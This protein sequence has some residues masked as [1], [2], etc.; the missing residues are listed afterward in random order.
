MASGPLTDGTGTAQFLLQNPPNVCCFTMGGGGRPF[1]RTVML[2]KEDFY[3]P[4]LLTNSSGTCIF[5]WQDIVPAGMRTLPA[6]GDMTQFAQG[7]AV[8][9]DFRTYYV[10]T[11]T[12]DLIMH[13]D[14]TFS[15]ATLNGFGA[16]P[17]VTGERLRVID[18]VY[19]FQVSLGYDLDDS[20]DVLDAN[21]A[22][23][24]LHN[25]PGES[26]GALGPGFDKAKLKLVRA[27]LVVGFPTGASAPSLARSPARDPGQLA[28]PGV[29]LR[30]VGTVLAPR[31]TP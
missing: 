17:T 30:A 16:D 18:G 28:V 21:G 13:M 23:E 1:V 19:D 8:L 12:H 9:I 11:E 22:D 26:A 14:Q 3:R 25:V 7:E 24:W 6:S 29:S 31:N 4:V 5:E 15:G 10:D 2:M 20:G 27:E